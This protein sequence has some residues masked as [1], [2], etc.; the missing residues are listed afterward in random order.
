MSIHQFDYE[1][2]CPPGQ[3]ISRILGMIV[4][5]ERQLLYYLGSQIYTGLG[6]IVELGCF[7]GLST[8]CFAKG[9]EANTRVTNKKAR[10][11]TFDWFRFFDE[12]PYDQWLRD[13]GIA[14]HHKLINLFLDH[15]KPWAEMIALRPGDIMDQQWNG[16]PIEILFVDCGRNWTHSDQIVEQ[17]YPSLMPGHSYLVQQDYIYW[18]NHWVAIT[19]EWFADCFEIVDC[20]HSTVTFKLTKPIPLERLQ[21]RVSS[22]P[23][24]AKI[25]LMDRA[26]ARASGGAYPVMLMAKANLV[27][28]LKGWKVA[29]PLI[30]EIAKEH[31]GNPKVKDWIG[32]LSMWQ[33]RRGYVLPPENPG[34]GKITWR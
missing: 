24:E 5:R 34:L 31:G 17:F 30:E 28:E 2:C 25:Q 32:E 11:N 3:D 7:V 10:I 20:S 13:R 21:K 9:L 4:D 14:D 6:E 19:M 22:L 27:A 33:T 8:T 23:D 12:P 26:V 18:H 1:S 15:T 16:R 29:E